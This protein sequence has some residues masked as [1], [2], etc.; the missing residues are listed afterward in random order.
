MSEIRS[1]EG[2]EVP[3]DG[4]L[5]CACGAP[6]PGRTLHVPDVDDS[7]T[8]SYAIEPHKSEL[9]VGEV[10]R[11]SGLAVSAIHFYESKG[12]IQ[13]RRNRANHRVYPRDVL[14]RIGVIKVAQKTGM[15][16]EEIREALKTLPNER[17]PTKEDW[18]RLSME[19]R[20]DLE[21]RIRRL[22]RLR[23]LLDGCIGCGC[24]SISDC[25]LRNPDDRLGLEGPGPRLLDPEAH[26]R[27]HD[28]G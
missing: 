21:A 8:G 6:S 10:A 17:T 18:T 5:A 16:L 22:I 11:R 2:C 1:A 20:A 14:R 19:W 7:G 23:D 12:L 13:S 9:T 24:L 26:S 28:G 15:S 3:S 27:R 4:A 25:P